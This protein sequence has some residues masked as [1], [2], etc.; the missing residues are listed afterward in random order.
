MKPYLFIIVG[1]VVVIALMAMGCD[2]RKVDPLNGPVQKEYKEDEVIAWVNGVAIS[3]EQVDQ[4][5]SSLPPQIQMQARSARGMKNLIENLVN[6]ELVY[7]LALKEGY[8]DRDEVK[9]K[10]FNITKQ[11]VYSEYMQEVIEKSGKVDDAEAQKFYDENPNLFA[12][13]AQVRASHILFKVK[14]DGS[15][16]TTQ[17]AKCEKILKLALKTDG[18]WDKLVKEHSE[19][20]AKDT[21]GDLGF[22]DPKMMAKTISEAAFKLKDNEINKECVK[23]HNGYHIL[24]KTG[25][26]EGETK[27]FDDVKAELITMLSRKNQQQVYEDTV[28]KLKTGADIKYNDKLMPAEEPAAMPPGLGGMMGGPGSAAPPTK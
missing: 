11:V 10:I 24:R 5:V 1:L 27:S 7:Q 16:D 8:M 9:Q 26:K 15:D 13:G 6:V 18:D 28:G 12:V 21:G 17:R 14:E 19:G 4:M 20:G 3:K 25:A 23:S 22:F 2:C